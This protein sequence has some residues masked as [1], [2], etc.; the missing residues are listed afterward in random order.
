M[1]LLEACAFA[2]LRAPRTESDLH[3][4]WRE[5]DRRGIKHNL[6]DE[7]GYKCWKATVFKARGCAVQVAVAAAR[8][9]MKP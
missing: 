2:R 3:A 1:T 8:R 5:L 9:G 6:I 7:P 4:I